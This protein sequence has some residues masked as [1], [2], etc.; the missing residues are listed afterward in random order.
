MR[1]D[2][3]NHTRFATFGVFIFVTVVFAV[4]SFLW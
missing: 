3:C 4:L 2:E 1:Y